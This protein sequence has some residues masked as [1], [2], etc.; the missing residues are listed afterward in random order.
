V[1][2]EVAGQFQSRADI[3]YF[4]FTAQAQ[5]VFAVEVFGD[6]D[7]SNADPYLILEQLTVD[8]QGR[9]TGAQQI[10]VQD[11]LGL[12]LFPEHFS[13][14]SDDVSYRLVVPADARYRISVR[15][16]YFE[17]R[18]DPRLTYR[19]AIRTERP[20]S[21]L[22]AVPLA[23]LNGENNNTATPWPIGLRQGDT[24]AVRVLAFRRDGFNAPISIEVEGLPPG[25]TYA[26]AT[27]PAGQNQT[28][29]VLSSAESA[30]PVFTTINL[31]GR[32]QVAAPSATADSAAGAQEL[33]R[34]ARAGTIVWEGNQQQPA[35][36]RVSQGL[37]LSVIDELAPWQIATDVARLE[38]SRGQEAFIP[39]K[40][41]KR[42]GFDANVTVTMEGQ[43]ANVQVE[44]KPINAGTTEEQQRI[45]VTPD[46][47]AGTY[48][49]LLRAQGQVAY[50]R[51]PAP[52]NASA[53]AAQPQNLNVTTYCT[54]IVL[55]IK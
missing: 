54:P 36:S 51:N 48:T 11:D 9:A 35:R 31:L 19:L 55:E 44:L 45:F 25:V 1:P 49:L 37:G 17:S 22:V 6:R 33:V 52:E 50:T 32:S 15:D 7:G 53:E 26:P 4:E 27:I 30:A 38:V 47:P 34:I 40:L 16:R 18:G 5:N 43:P 24:F 13:T 20:D 10:T 8:E 2:A 23:P 46:A 3:D 39:V 42:N 28:T 29:L 41:T 14:R 21:R 12:D